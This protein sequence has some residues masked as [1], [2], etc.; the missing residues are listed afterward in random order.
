MD[1]QWISD[2]FFEIANLLE[3]QGE[4]PFR[5]RAYRRAAQTISHFRSEVR[6]LAQEGRLQE[7]PGVGKILTRDITQ[8]IETGGVP[9]HEHLKSTVPEGLLS[10]LRLPSLTPDQV[11]L[12]WRKHN[13]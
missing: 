7:I 11:R 6:F 5:I 9:Y 12:L 2:T 10:V 3:L 13:I 1:N 4:D 8:L